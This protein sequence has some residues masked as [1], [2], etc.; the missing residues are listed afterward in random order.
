MIII[1]TDGQHRAVDLARFPAPVLLPHGASHVQETPDACKVLRLQ[2]RGH[3]PPKRLQFGVKE[4][5]HDAILSCLKVH[6]RGRGCG[7]DSV[8][9][10][11]GKHEAGLL[12]LPP[13]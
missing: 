11:E 9:S 8:H 3:Y 5:T 2:L 7:S 12:F 4:E 10:G 1:Q 6:S 13:A